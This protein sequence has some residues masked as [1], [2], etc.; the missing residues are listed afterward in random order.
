M[1]NKEKGLTLLEILIA[2][3]IFAAGI[4]VVLKFQGDLLRNLGG[5]QQQAEAISLAENKLNELRHY[6]VIESGGSGT[7]YQD[8]SSG[9]E[10]IT[11]NNTAYSVAW[12]VTTV[13]DPAYKTIQVTVSWTD[14]TGAA[15][16]VKLESIVGEV[17]PAKSGEV[18]QGL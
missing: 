1:R 8:I 18:M 2:I 7:A 13:A 14:S 17:D 15:Q 16:S 10:V 9:S 11:S 3:A 6:T 4:A 12:S 5:T